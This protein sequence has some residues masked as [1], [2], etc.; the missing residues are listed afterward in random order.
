LGFNVRF[1]RFR[2]RVPGMQLR[3]FVEQDVDTVERLGP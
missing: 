2:F 3:M 1:R